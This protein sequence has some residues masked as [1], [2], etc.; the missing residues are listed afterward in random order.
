[1]SLKHKYFY[2]VRLLKLVLILQYKY[3]IKSYWH[4]SK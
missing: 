3:I 2:N 4:L 1:M